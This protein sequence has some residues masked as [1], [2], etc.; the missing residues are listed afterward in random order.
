M[1]F[2]ADENFPRPDLEALRKAGRDVFSIA[3]S[4]PG[5]SHDEVITVAGDQGRVLLTFDKDFGELVSQRGLPAVSGVVLFRITPESPESHWR[6]SNPN[7]IL[8]GLSACSHAIGFEFAGWAALGGPEIKGCLVYKK[9]LF[10]VLDEELTRRVRPRARSRWAATADPWHGRVSEGT[11]A[12]AR[13]REERR[14]TSDLL[15]SW[16]VQT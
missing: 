10:F 5:I 14:G 3:E 7:R 12:P 13:E 16:S 2:L 4:C 11:L 15:L 6:W 8:P 1:K 9:A